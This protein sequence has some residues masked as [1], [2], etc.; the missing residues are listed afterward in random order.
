MNLFANFEMHRNDRKQT[1]YDKKG[2]CN[3]NKAIIK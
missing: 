2:P 3:Q 1:L